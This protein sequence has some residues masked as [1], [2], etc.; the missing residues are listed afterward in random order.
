MDDASAVDDAEEDE[1]KME[2]ERPAK[3][4]KVGK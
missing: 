1:V 3:K 4:T 2:E